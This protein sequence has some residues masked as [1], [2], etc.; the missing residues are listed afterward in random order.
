MGTLLLAVLNATS[1]ASSIVFGVLND[2]FRVSDIVLVS[3]LGSA[4]AVLLLWGLAGHVAPLAVF[5]AAYGF[6]AGGFSSTWSGV[7][8]ELHRQ[9]PALD[10]GLVFGLLAGGRGIGNVAS[11]P[12][13]AVLLDEANWKGSGKLTGYSTEYGPMI[14]FTGVTAFFG[15]WG[16]LQRFLRD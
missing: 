15:G 1:I 3:S 7:Q 5:A 8:S 13:S 10:T 2:R 12:L 16:W 11:G 9:S 14:V 6:F 4:A